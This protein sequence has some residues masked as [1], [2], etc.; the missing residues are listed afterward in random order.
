MELISKPRRQMVLRVPD[1]LMKIIVHLS[2]KYY[3]PPNKN[4]STLAVA[5]C[6]CYVAEQESLSSRIPKLYELTLK[7]FRVPSSDRVGPGLDKEVPLFG[8]SVAIGQCIHP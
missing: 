5:L 1:G 2:K 7:L 4:T 3:L 6:F 8:L